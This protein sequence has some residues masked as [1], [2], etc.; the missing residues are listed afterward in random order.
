MIHQLYYELEP[1][2]ALLIPG[3]WF[4]A[5]RLEESSLAVSQFNAGLMPL[6]VGGGP[7]KSWEERAYMQGWG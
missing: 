3:F 1:G 4:H 6:A 2:D 7:R 5:V